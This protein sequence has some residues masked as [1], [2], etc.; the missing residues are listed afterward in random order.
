MMHVILYLALLGATAFALPV[1]NENNHKSLVYERTG[2]VDI[3]PITQTQ[4][5]TQTE[6]GPP[7]SNIIPEKQIREHQ[8]GR[9]PQNYDKDANGLLDQSEYEGWRAAENIVVLPFEAV[10]TNDDRFVNSVELPYLLWSS[11]NEINKALPGYDDDKYLFNDMMLTNAFFTDDVSDMVNIP[12][13]TYM[14]IIVHTK[15]AGDGVKPLNV[16]PVNN[17][18]DDD[19]T[20]EQEHVDYVDKKVISEVNPAEEEF[21]Q[22][23]MVGKESSFPQSEEPEYIDPV[24]EEVIDRVNPAEG[25]IIDEVNPDEEGNYRPKE[26]G[27]I[28][29]IHGKENTFPQSEEPESMDPV[30]EEDI[31]EINP[32]E[33]GI[34]QPEEGGL[35]DSMVGKESTFPQ[36]EEPE[37]MDPVDEEDI[38]EINP[39]E[40]GIFQ[41]EE[42]GLVDSMVGKESNF[43]QLEEPE[44]MDP[45]DEEDIDEINP[46]EEGI[47]QTEE[48]SLIDFMVGEENTFPQSEEP[49]SMDPVDEE[50]IDEINPTEEGIYQPEEGGLIDSMVGKESTFPQSEEPESMDPVDEEVI[51]ETNPTEEGIYQPEE[52]GLIDSM[53]GKEYFSSVRRTRIYG[54]C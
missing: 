10:D 44:S 3:N 24:D 4:V 33:E 5:F 37:S 23:D 50:D 21:Y 1:Y 19:N 30:D 26:D 17:F 53:V 45:V 43:P 32:A 28:R 39:A 11:P 49:E 12:K 42:G 31:D 7:V 25:E 48:G 47:S 6:R 29:F 18:P 36:S 8:P 38:D 15:P 34:F 20:E 41:P 52:G 51:D 46:A 40:E 13:E 16:N 35:I 14:S 27:I 54:S 9:I 2:P 22:P